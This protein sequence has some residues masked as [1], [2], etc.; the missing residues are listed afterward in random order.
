M[1]S[2]ICIPIVTN[3]VEE[4]ERLLACYHD[5]VDMFELWLDY[6]KPL[7][8]A[9]IKNLCLKYPRRLIL[10]FRRQGNDLPL[11]AFEIRRDIY[12]ALSDVE[13]FFDCDIYRFK[14]DLEWFKEQSESYRIIC[15]YH[16]FERTPDSERLQSIMQEMHVFKPAIYKIATYCNTR[17]DAL[18]LLQLLLLLKQQEKSAIILGMGEE[19]VVTRFAGSIWGNEI[20]F[21]P[22]PDTIHTAPGQLTLEQIMNFYSLLE[23]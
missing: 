15:S 16:N 9:S 8:V 14:E 1:K 2:K 18:V 13:V 6:L 19:G 3:S 5:R 21:A 20:I 7:E 12:Q 22:A 4:I 17:E 23:K 11:T 10:L